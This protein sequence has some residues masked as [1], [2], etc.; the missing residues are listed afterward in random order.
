MQEPEFCIEISKGI[1]CSFQISFERIKSFIQ[2]FAG[3]FNKLLCKY[4][5]VGIINITGSLKT[6]CR[7]I[8]SWQP[9]IR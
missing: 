3:V 8:K 7:Y 2:N 6:C 1:S 5:P 9:D 4:F